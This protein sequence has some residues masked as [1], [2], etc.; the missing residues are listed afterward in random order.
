[1]R[2]LKITFSL[3][4]AL[5][6]AIGLIACD[7]PPANNST[8]RPMTNNN[9]TLGNAAN[10]VA[11]TVEKAANSVSNAIS[12]A[13][14]DD[15]GDFVRT[16]AQDGNAEVV[17]GKL[18]AGKTK[19]AQ[20]KAFANMMVT[21]HTAAGTELKSIATKKKFDFPSD[22]GS[23]QSTIDSLN[24]A[25]DSFDK[26]YVDEMVKAHEN[27]VSLFQK[28][29][30][31]GTDADLKAFASKTLPKLKEHLDKIKKIQSEMK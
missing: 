2:I 6:M 17:M 21:D 31:N 11:N 3:T 28:Q 30:D 20:I 7:N 23:N 29:A 13:T 8:N 15:P 27:A 14:T 9:S 16:A 18:A 25:T 10:T 5:G 24:K 1:M 12:S 26:D 22:N 19:N 4:A